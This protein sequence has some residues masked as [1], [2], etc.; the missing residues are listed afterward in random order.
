MPGNRKAAGLTL[1]VHFGTASTSILAN[2]SSY[3]RLLVKW[4]VVVKAIDKTGIIPPSLQE[5]VQH[6]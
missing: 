5:H 2:I 4:A 3:F 6:A 1:F